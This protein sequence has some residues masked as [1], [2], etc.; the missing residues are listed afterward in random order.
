MGSAADQIAIDRLRALLPAIQQVVGQAAQTG[1]RALASA[2]QL[3]SLQTQTATGSAPVVFRQSKTAQE[4]ISQAM[5]GGWKVVKARTLIP[6]VGPAL[7]G[8][9]LTIDAIEWRDVAFLGFGNADLAA[10]QFQ[11]YIEQAGSHLYA[12]A[13]MQHDDFDALGFTVRSYRLLLLH[14]QIQIGA[15]VIIA[16]VVA[17]F[18]ALV[19]YQY[20]TQGS[21]PALDELTKVWR[22]L[23]SATVNPVAQA[24]IS[25]W[26]VGAVAAAGIALA[27]GA[28]ARRLDVKA[29][30][31]PKPPSIG[32]EAEARSKAGKIG[33]SV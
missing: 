6:D 8:G 2:G 9:H 30:P 12:W 18:A 27:S 10:S 31:A 1:P 5:A 11:T 4:L 23:V 17:A 21:S 25:W 22:D 24:A 16:I 32:I 33:V 20:Y 19:I 15:G 7:A 14:S 29:P 13:V 28:V 3:I 26:V